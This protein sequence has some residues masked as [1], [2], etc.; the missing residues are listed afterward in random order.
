MIWIKFRNQDPEPKNLPFVW[1]SKK[2]LFSEVWDDTDWFNE[3]TDVDKS[4]W[5]WW[6]ELTDLPE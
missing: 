4:E 5:E 2:G 1:R 6:A 3:L